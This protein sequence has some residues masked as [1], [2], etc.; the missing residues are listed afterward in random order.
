MKEKA[1]GS[2]TAR[3]RDKHRPEAD[4]LASSKEQL[5]PSSGR[6]PVSQN[7]MWREHNEE[8]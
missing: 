6:D 4:W 2:S 7:T 5:V 3:G 8:T 1:R